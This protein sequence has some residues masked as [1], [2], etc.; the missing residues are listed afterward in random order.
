[1]TT[2]KYPYK[3]FNLRIRFKN[4]LW[5]IPFSTLHTDFK[6][7]ILEFKDSS[8]NYWDLFG[9]EIF[10]GGW[11]YVCV[12]KTHPRNGFWAVTVNSLHTF[13][14]FALTAFSCFSESG[15][16]QLYVVCFLFHGCSSR[17]HLK[18]WM[19]CYFHQAMSK[20]VNFSASIRTFPYL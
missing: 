14:H 15:T 3:K 18:A 17:M 9:L 13:V 11:M 7:Y 2:V 20:K 4:Y 12:I 10:F 1:M 16:T 19:R 8:A 5:I 6:D